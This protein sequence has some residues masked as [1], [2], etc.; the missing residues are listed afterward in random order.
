MDRTMEFIARSRP[1]RRTVVFGGIAAGTLAVVDPACRQARA[2]LAA[3][4]AS[5]APRDDTAYSLHGVTIAD[6]YRPLEDAARADVRAWIDAENG[7][8]R[9]LI[10]SLPIRN[11]VHDF[12]LA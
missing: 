12:F 7:R 3:G 9:T 11:Q 1:K 8:A 6:P 10:D 5:P 4:V 2:A